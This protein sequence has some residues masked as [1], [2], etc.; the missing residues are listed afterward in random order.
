MRLSITGMVFWY[1]VIINIVA[2]FVYEQDKQNA[3]RYKRRIPENT[4]LLLG[5]L[6]GGIGS[7]VAM[8]SLHHKTRHK[9]FVILVPLFILLHALLVFTLWYFHIIG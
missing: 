5:I 3:R 6:G 1:Y 9:N 2:F 4:L 8:Y 7:L